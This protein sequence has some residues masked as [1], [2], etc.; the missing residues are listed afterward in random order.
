MFICKGF[1]GEPDDYRGLER[2]DGGGGGGREKT[3]RL[4]ALELRRICMLHDRGL[5]VEGGGKN[6]SINND[7]L[8]IIPT[9]EK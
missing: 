7:V 6:P 3:Q 1:S 9:L 4:F 5:D 8:V 2:R